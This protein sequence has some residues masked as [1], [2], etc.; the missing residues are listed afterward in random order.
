M[1]KP[2]NLDEWAEHV[3]ANTVGS[4]VSFRQLAERDQTP[5]AAADRVEHMLQWM[6][7]AVV[8][9]AKAKG[10]AAMGPVQLSEAQVERFGRARGR[11]ERSL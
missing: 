10:A 5:E 1:L 2:D 8:G 9:A 6:H 3:R 7:R 4:E 11:H